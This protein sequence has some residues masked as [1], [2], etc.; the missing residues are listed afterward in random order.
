[1]H[2]EAT[3]SI[4]ESMYTTKRQQYENAGCTGG[5]PWMKVNQAGVGL[6]RPSV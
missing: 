1:M 4:E 2:T 6:T 3:S 5:K